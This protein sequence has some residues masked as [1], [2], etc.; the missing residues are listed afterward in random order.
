M[1]Q[2]KIQKLCHYNEIT[3]IEFSSD[4][5]SIFVLENM[6]TSLLFV[7]SFFFF[8]F[9]RRQYSYRVAIIELRHWNL[10]FLELIL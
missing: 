10:L 6:Q 5:L 2:I 8:R 4:T 3:F 9:V 1:E 7:I